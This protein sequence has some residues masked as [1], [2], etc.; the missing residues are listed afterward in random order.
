VVLII[1]VYISQ[2][3]CKVVILVKNLAKVSVDFTQL[4]TRATSLLEVPG[5]KLGPENLL[6]HSMQVSSLFRLVL[7]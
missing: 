6:F 1:N 3:L 7:L 5:L 4:V 2:F